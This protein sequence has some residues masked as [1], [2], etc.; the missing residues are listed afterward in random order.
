MTTEAQ[1]QPLTEY[2]RHLLAQFRSDRARLVKDYPVHWLDAND[3]IKIE[4]EALDAARASEPVDGHALNPD[5]IETEAVLGPAATEP[6]DGLRAA[7]ERFS[8][9]RDGVGECSWCHWVRGTYP[10]EAHDADCPMGDVWRALT[11][12]PTTGEPTP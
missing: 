6:A 2:G 4:R 10:E 1:P 11:P 8:W 7:L 12:S 3:I 9:G 5:H